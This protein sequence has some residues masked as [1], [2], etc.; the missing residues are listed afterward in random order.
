MKQIRV[1]AFLENLFRDLRDRRLL[2]PAIV[3]LV[4]LF[5]VPI[6]L[7]SHSSTS[8]TSVAPAEEAGAMADQAVPAVV[9]QQLGVTNYRKRLNQLQSKNPFH[10]QYTATPESAQLHITNAGSA[11]TGTTSTSGTTSS[12]TGVTSS[13]GSLPPV[14]SSTPGGT[15]PVSSPPVTSSGGSNSGVGHRTKPKVGY[16]A[17]RVSVKVG[18]PGHLKDRAEVQR[19]AMLPSEGKPATTFLGATEDGSKALFLVSADVDSVKGDGHCLPSHASCRYVVMDPGDKANLHYAPNNTR[20]NIV[21][22]D[23]HP[24]EVT[25]KLPKKPSGKAQPQQKLPLL[26]DG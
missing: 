4:A 16:Y 11:S 24:V 21:L 7:K 1:P 17:W 26:G 20:Y 13:T 18:E 12:T 3:L 19:L 14:S 25:D 5:A 6:V 9:M 8:A 15:S 2:L 10:Q 23:I 22:V